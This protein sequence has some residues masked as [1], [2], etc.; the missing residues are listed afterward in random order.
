M[1]APQH[2]D[3]FVNIDDSTGEVMYYVANALPSTIKGMVCEDCGEPVTVINA[4][5]SYEE[6]K[7]AYQHEREHLK[8]DDFHTDK[9]ADKL[10]KER[11]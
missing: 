9:K 2:T 5:C 11:H 3:I 8:E 10:E 4:N 6:Q 7:K 1:R